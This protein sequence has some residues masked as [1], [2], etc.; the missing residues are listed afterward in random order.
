MPGIIERELQK[1]NVPNI[2]SGGGWTEQRRAEVLQLVTENVYGV[3]P[4]APVNVKFTEKEDE[5][6][7]N[8]FCGKAVFKKIIAECF[9]SD[10]DYPG[11]ASRP[12][13]NG[14]FAFEISCYLPKNTEGKKIAAAVAI[15]YRES[16]DFHNLSAELAVSR[17]AAVFAFRYRHI[18]NDYPE[19]DHR[20]FDG[21]GL[22]RLYYG[23][24]MKEMGRDERGPSGPGTIPFWA[25]GAM[26][27]MDYI[28]TLDFVDRGRV[29]V[30]GH[31]RLAKTAL[32]AGAHDTRFTHVFCNASCAAGVALS[33]GDRKQNLFNMSQWHTL[34]FCE[35]INKFSLPANQ[36]EPFDQH[37]LVA[38]V[39]PRKIY[40]ANSDDDAFCD[41]LS[42]FLSLAAADPVFKLLGCAGLSRPDRL[43]VTGDR[44]AEGSAAYHLRPGK[45]S[46]ADEDW[47]MFLDWL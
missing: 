3:I 23:K 42:E 26:R 20:Q 32:L 6:D 27:V 45:H 44:F 24:S 2:F 31:S 25:W 18:V 47:R 30:C 13:L 9:L 29:A 17:G 7:E 19:N 8:Y 39:A 14:R 22:D 34:W 28:E 4:P 43:P 37:F 12:E 11:L 38:C 10:K 33:R 16:H 15:H 46:F 40:V 35:N 1:R 36:T 21:E 5:R 41:E